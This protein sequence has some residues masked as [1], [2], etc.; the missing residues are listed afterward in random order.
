MRL[1]HLDIL[2]RKAFLADLP[3]GKL[4]INTINA[5]SYVN[6]RKDALFA[7]ALKNSDILIIYFN[8]INYIS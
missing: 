2:C 8:L 3:D 4:L 7:E 6:A 1:K 5:F